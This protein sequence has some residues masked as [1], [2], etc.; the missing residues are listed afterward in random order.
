LTIDESLLGYFRREAA[1]QPGAFTG[2]RFTTAVSG[3]VAIEHYHRYLFARAFCQGRDVLDVASGEGYG[4]A[5]IAQVARSVIGLEYAGET[6]RLARANFSR[7]NLQF[8]NGDARSLP[9]PDASVDIVV[10][11]ETIEHFAGQTAFVAEVHRVL[12]PD[13]CFIVSTPDRDNYAPTGTPTN[14]HHVREL[15]RREFAALLGR[16]FTHIQT[17][18]Q[19]PLIGSALVAEAA[20]PAVPLVFER[21]DTDRF[22]ACVG[23]P[24]PLYIVSV[25]ANVPIALPAN[26]LYIERSDLDTDARATAA[27]SAELARSQ[28]EVRQALMALQALRGQ[29]TAVEQREIEVRR[30]LAVRQAEYRRL[31]AE[32]V[33][34]STENA[35][36]D[37]LAGSLRLFLRAYLPRLRQH[38][39]GR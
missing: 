19:R 4:S 21:R 36:L 26:S 39:L 35:E 9:F 23:L 10:S 24:R 12:R 7:D 37:R 32:G 31:A 2:E 38:F 22:E 17:L 33:R 8:V 13:G 1:R 11:F 18:Y 34:L 25:A 14:G 30:Q 15:S 29:L 27:K 16:H 28:E 20:S 5:Q 6:V 3:Q